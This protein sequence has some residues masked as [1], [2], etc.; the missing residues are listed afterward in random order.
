MYNEVTQ[1]LNH[2]TSVQRRYQF[3]ACCEKLSPEIML[4]NNTTSPQFEII[5]GE[6]IGIY[7]RAGQSDVLNRMSRERYLELRLET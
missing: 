6:V 7:E 1:D 2:L 5:I 3:D 4:V